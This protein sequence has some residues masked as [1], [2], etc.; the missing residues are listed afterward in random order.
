MFSR[1]NVHCCA[2]AVCALHL[3]CTGVPGAMSQDAAKTWQ[4]SDTGLIWTVK[5]N[6]E[7][8]NWNQARNYCSRMDLDGFSDWRMPTIDELKSIFDKSQSKTYKAKGPIELEMPTIW[9]SSQNQVGDV[10]SYN[11]SYGGRSLSPTGGCGSAGRT[12]C[13]HE[14]NK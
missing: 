14:A 13:V 10:W 8:V 12:L 5:D 3:L 11:F 9:S 4:D 6:G 1:K 2:L 7:D